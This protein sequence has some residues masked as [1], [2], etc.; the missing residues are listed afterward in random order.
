MRESS[1]FS[2]PLT[3]DNG[4]SRQS[5]AGATH[6][7]KGPSAEKDTLESEGSLVS[8][9]RFHDEKVDTVRS[10]RPAGLGARSSGRKG[11]AASHGG[12]LRGVRQET[13]RRLR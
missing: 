8:L 5:R 7:F 13:W 9:R 4:A 3:R 10:D 6:F 2:S 12:I 11:Q 1:N